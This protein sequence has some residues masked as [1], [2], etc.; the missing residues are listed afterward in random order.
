MRIC[1]GAQ[2]KKLSVILSCGLPQCLCV[3]QVS[4]PQNGVT[5]WWSTGLVMAHHTE[6]NIPLFEVAHRPHDQGGNEF[7]S[8][9]LR[10]GH[11]W[12]CI[13]FSVSHIRQFLQIWTATKLLWINFQGPRKHSNSKWEVGHDQNILA[14]RHGEKEGGRNIYCDTWEQ[15]WKKWGESEKF[16]IP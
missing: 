14:P 2:H 15:S 13:L 1:N 10:C 3:I 6:V 7:P 11:T 5:E 12:N 9:Q 16:T 4:Q 8:L